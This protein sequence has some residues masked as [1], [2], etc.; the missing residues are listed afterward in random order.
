MARIEIFTKEWCPYCKKAKALLRIKG[1]EYDEVDIT[2]DYA[3]QQRMIERSGRRTVPQVFLDGKS[4]G[5]YD[6]LAH[7]N[8]V[9]E[10]DRVLGIETT[11]DLARLYDVAIIG[12]GPA[13]LTAAIYASRKN[14]STI[15]IAEDI[16]GQMGTTVEVAN[17]PGFQMVTGPDLVQAFYEHAAEHDIEELVGEKVTG[18]D[19]DGRVK[20][21]GLA[22]GRSV[23]ARTVI[24]ATGVHKRRLGVPGEK[25]L[26]GKGVVYCS[27]CD[28]PLFRGKRIAVVG[29]GNSGLEA[30]IEMDGMASKV[31]AISRRDWTGDQ[32]LQDKVSSAGNVEVLKFYQPVEVHGEGEVEG[33]TVRNLE[34]GEEK[35]LDVEGVFVEIGLFPNT[36]F[37]LDVVET[38]ERGEIKVDHNNQTG[39]RGVFAAGDVTDGYHKQIILSAA[40]GARA[41]LSAFQY[42]VTQ[43]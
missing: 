32:I 13:G 11:V 36:D 39:V 15:V 29:G 35:R 34:T 6:D 2:N 22:S 27:T 23:S 10:L 40:D 20:K 28:G 12:G 7:L 18:L 1:V 30:A 9:G 17:Y 26:S 24:I 21:V 14:M 19:F 3:M 38:N 25:E 43:V 16:G 31:F 4:V 8:A 33:L 41:A 42:L 37:V 5:G